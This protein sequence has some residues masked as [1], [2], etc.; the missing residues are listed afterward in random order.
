MSPDLNLKERIKK[1]TNYITIKN[2]SMASAILN[3]ASIGLGIMYLVNPIYSL[4]WDIFGVIL[5]V[6]LIGNLILV[7]VSTSKL[8]KTSKEGNRINLLCYFYLVFCIVA[9]FLMLFGNMLI[10]VTYSNELSWMLGGYTMILS[11]YFC[12]L[13]IGLL[14][15]YFDAKYLGNP[16]L[17]DLSQDFEHIQSKNASTT[18]KILKKLLKID[19][20]CTLAFGIYF[21]YV[22]LNGHADY[23]SGVVGVFT[24]QFPTFA[25]IIFLSTTVILLMLKKKESNPKG[26]YSV[27]M[28][29][30][31]ISGIFLL[32]LFSVNITIWR[33]EA[34]FSE[35]FGADWRDRIN[36]SVEESYFMKTPFTTPQI[37]LGIP[38]KDCIVLE[39]QLFFDGPIGTD[40]IQLY[41]DAYMPLN[42]GVGLPGQNS[43]LIR[44]HGG[45]WVF[46]DK[47]WGNLMQMNKYFA[48]QG[49][50]VF[51]IQYAL[52]KIDAL[53]W[54]PLTPKYRK[55]DFN[56]DQ[57]VASLGI[58]T[59]YL[60]NHSEEFGA[61]LDSVFV[62]GGSAGGQLTCAL[63]LGIWSGLYQSV[64]GPNLTIK[65][66]I[67]FY[68]GNDLSNHLLT[69]GGDPNLINPPLLINAS[70]P[71]CLVYQG[72][73]DGLVKPTT[74]QALKDAYT[75]AGTKRSSIIWLPFSGH[76]NDIYF[77]G[78]YNQIFLYYMERFLYL[79][80]NNLI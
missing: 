56:I 58:F 49:Y 43:T 76:A 29:G 28:I 54:D 31:I 44:I 63:A 40:T 53:D 6:T 4:L 1:I 65:G 75:N 14:I 46:G 42:N 13:G 45:G 8:N 23:V 9:M 20:Y 10:S 36:S 73:Q 37:F 48:A 62:S 27:T 69:D 11:G 12:L 19:C 38:P 5:I 25:A 78:H 55:G 2:V 57:I 59:K 71:P 16:R 39:H 7:Y 66:Y 35:A 68:P 17:W 77:S 74:S 41:Y 26:Y 80:V 32:P 67:P 61:N 50:I 51:D 79:C 21:S 64:F 52:R 22:L 24:N 18:K 72:E 70:A 33:A 47:G 60:S 15:A 34:S 3:L 30:L